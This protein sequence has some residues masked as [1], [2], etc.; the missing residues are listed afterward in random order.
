M[1]L[2]SYHNISDSLVA[3]A[4]SVN[5]ES[6]KKIDEQIMDLLDDGKDPKF[7]NVKIS[8]ASLQRIFQVRES[9]DYEDRK[10]QK[11]RDKKRREDRDNKKQEP[12]SEDKKK[13]LDDNDLEEAI[14][15]S[16][17]DAL[18]TAR[19]Q[20]TKKPAFKSAAEKLRPKISKSVTEKNAFG[21]DSTWLGQFTSHYGS[22]DDLLATANSSNRTSADPLA[23]LADI[24][25]KKA[26]APPAALAPSGARVASPTTEG[27]HPAI[28]RGFAGVL[29]Q[30]IKK[31][32]FKLDNKKDR[33]EIARRYKTM[34]KNHGDTDKEKDV[35]EAFTQF[36]EGQR[37][38]DQK[39]VP[40][41]GPNGQVIWKNIRKVVNLTP[42]DPNNPSNDLVQTFEQHE[43]IL[44]GA[45]IRHYHSV[46]YKHKNGKWA[47]HFDADTK[48]DAT[49]EQES[50]RRTG[51][52]TVRLTVPRAE[53]K[54]WTKVNVHDYVEGRLSKKNE[55][56]LIENE[57]MVRSYRHPITKDYRYL[58]QK[59]TGGNDFVVTDKHYKPIGT[60]KDSIESF[61]QKMTNAGYKKQ[62]LNEEIHSADDD[63]EAD[64]HIL[65]Q[66]RKAAI[67]GGHK[68]VKFANGEKV[69]V[70]P[71]HASTFVNKYMNGSHQEK[72]R[73]QTTAQKSHEHFL[74]CVTEAVDSK[75]K[76]ELRQT[77]SKIDK[78]DVNHSAIKKLIK[79][80]YKS[81]PGAQAR[82]PLEDRN[83]V[84][85]RNLKDVIRDRNQ[86]VKPNLPESFDQLNTTE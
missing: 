29:S 17:V 71:H 12:V 80:K 6:N 45:L 67:M 26:I 40:V 46:F 82:D 34:D 76:D 9:Q 60:H 49:D 66:M 65:V 85:K 53:A 2:K 62:K 24:K 38:G 74:D 48:E 3:A 10:A 21:A 84:H 44:E 42:Q 32:E 18:N 39:R 47:H 27:I 37:T 69:K 64:N 83:V 13:I 55:D 33:R 25:K 1:S 70:H 78:R 57:H 54:N 73:L 52:K 79:H 30:M 5:A 36:L 75:T 43:N 56:I 59:N 28:K 81:L 35:N 72:E 22:A 50:L 23:K 51:H 63:L 68:E 41:K 77:V 4:L 7:I 15:I 16:A 20:F 61:H 8:G 19:T 31:G 86:H 14:K 58:F 11:Q